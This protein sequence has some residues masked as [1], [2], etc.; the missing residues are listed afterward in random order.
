MIIALSSCGYTVVSGPSQL[1]RKSLYVGGFLESQPFGIAIELRRQLAT[2]LAAD[3]FDLVTDP[4]D[5][6]VMLSGTL[7]GTTGSPALTLS[8]GTVPAYSAQ[9]LIKV[10]L[11]DM[12]GAEIWHST[13]RLS[14]DFLAGDSRL[15]STPNFGLV[16]ESN[17]RKALHRLAQ[18]AAQ[19]VHTRFLLQDP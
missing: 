2:L 14:E 15:R 3:G 4:S 5:A 19:S 13:V 18:H 9:V 17:R 12:A 7:L 10:R 11:T 16:T 8:G 1:A 6:E